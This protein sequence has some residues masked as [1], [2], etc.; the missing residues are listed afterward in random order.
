MEAS[1]T[2]SGPSVEPLRLAREASELLRE[3]LSRRVIV[4]VVDEEL[5]EVGDEDFGGSGDGVRRRIRKSRMSTVCILSSCFLVSSTAA[6]DSC[7]REAL[8]S[9]VTE[10]G[11]VLR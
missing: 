10:S 3:P 11:F 8:F 5:R 9:P 7:R 6:T 4:G 2:S 1:D